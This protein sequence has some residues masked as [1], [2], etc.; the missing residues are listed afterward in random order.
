MQWT[1][2]NIL[3]L[4]EYWHRLAGGE[5]PERA[6]F[7][8]EEVQPLLPYLMLCDFEPA[9][10]RVRYRLSGTRVD[11]MTGMNLAGRY[12]DEFA[13]G[14]YATAVKEMLGFYETASRTGRPH[15]WNYAWVGD[16]PNQKM[17]WAGIFPLKVNGVIAQ[18]ISIEDYSALS[19]LEDR[20]V[21]PLD[22]KTRRD[23]SRLH[24]A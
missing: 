22:P 18:C 12:L 24:R 21:Q 6:Q 19:K 1:P 20:R 2:K 9:P 4:S 15:V 10:F 7:R 16:N 3:K 17:I 5:T 14:A 23:W 11:E 13:D 8:V